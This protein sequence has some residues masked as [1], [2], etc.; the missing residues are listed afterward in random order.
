[1]ASMTDDGISIPAPPRGH[2]YGVVLRYHST[3]VA[4]SKDWAL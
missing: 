1:M 3:T 4:W 2:D